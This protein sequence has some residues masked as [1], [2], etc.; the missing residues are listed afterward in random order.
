MANY[1]EIQGFPI[2]NL[3]TDPKPYAQALADNPY[4]G[5]WAS[6]GNMNHARK[7][8]PG[9]GTQTSALIAG[10]DDGGLTPTFT[11]VEEYNGTS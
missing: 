3:T 11:E 1:K 8:N 5:T 2:Q 4:Q 10:G 6:G 9:D 7:R